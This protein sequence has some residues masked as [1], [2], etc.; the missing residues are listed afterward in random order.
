MRSLIDLESWRPRPLHAGDEGVV[1]CYGSTEA[2][3]V[4]QG[5]GPTKTYSA[6]TKVRTTIDSEAFKPKPM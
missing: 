2:A 4:W 5:P 6:V 3:H 1:E